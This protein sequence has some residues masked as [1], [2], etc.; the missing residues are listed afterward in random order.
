MCRYSKP[1]TS[2]LR[3]QMTCSLDYVMTEAGY[4]IANFEI[5]N[6]YLALTGRGI[7]F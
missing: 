4:D 6:F 1:W 5:V 3:G 2:S 7:I